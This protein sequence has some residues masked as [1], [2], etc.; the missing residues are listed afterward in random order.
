MAGDSLFYFLAFLDFFLV[1][2][3]MISNKKL[4]PYDTLLYG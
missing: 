3:M 2:R 1:V 4:T